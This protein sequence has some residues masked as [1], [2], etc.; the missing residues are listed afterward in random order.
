[1]RGRAGSY[2]DSLRIGCRAIVWVAPS[3]TKATGD[4]TWL[5]AVGG[6]GGTAFGPLRCGN[7]GVVET[8]SGRGATYVDSLTMTCADKVEIWSP[9][10]GP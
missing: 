6:T 4:T 3:T 8:L 1:M 5:T 2:V 10:T 7:N 9:N